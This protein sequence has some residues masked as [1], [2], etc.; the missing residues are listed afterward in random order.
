VG[1][2]RGLVLTNPVLGLRKRHNE[3]PKE[4]VLSDGEIR[5]LWHATAVMG[6]AYRDVLRLIL[7]TGQRPGEVAGIRGGDVNF[8]H[9]LWTLP[10]ERVKNKRRHLVPLTGEALTIIRKR[11]EGAG[12]GPLF[13]TPRGHTPTSQDVAKAFERLR[14]DGVFETPATP[15]D[16]RR[17]A[18]TL[19]GRLEIDQMTIAR[20]LNHASTTKATV[21][22]STYDRHTYE[23]QMRRA[24]QALDAEIGRIVSGVQPPHNVLAF[25]T[26]HS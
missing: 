1:R 5:T 25:S 12:S 22:G 24:L 10:P 19:M 14:Q 6:P 23:P 2:V 16:L 18:A 9:A 8:E 3:V 7:L 4:R 21:T 11:G 15:H 17:T 20:V 13:I 26:R